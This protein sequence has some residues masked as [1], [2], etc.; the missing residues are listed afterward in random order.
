MAVQLYNTLTRR[1]EPLETLEPGRVKMYVCGVT[2]YDHCHLGHARAAI[3]FDVIRRYL[4][5]R[6]YQVTFVCNFTDVDDKIIARARRLKIPIGQLTEQFIAEYYNDMDALGVRRADVSPRATENID[7]MVKMIQGLM[8]KGLAYAGAGDVYYD[9]SR[10]PAYG[11]L[12]HRALEELEAG[13]RVE[14]GEGK[15]HPLDFALWKASKP[16]EPAWDSPWGPGRPGWHIEC[17]VMSSRYLG[18]RFDIHGGGE[19]LI[20]PHHE[21]EIAQSEGCFGHD[22][23]RYWIHNGFVRINHEKMSKSKGN[24]F[25]IK[26]VLQDIP[27]EVVRFFLLGSHYRHPVDYSDQ[28]VGEAWRGLDRLYNLLLRLGLAGPGEG[29]E[30]ERRMKEEAGIFRARFAEAMDDDFNSA[31]ALGHLFD[32]ARQAN[33]ILLDA[34]GALTRAAAAPAAEALREVGRVLGLFT[35]EPEEW[36]RRA[37][38]GASGEENN[39]QLAD[40]QI[41]ELIARRADAR[42]RKDFEEADRIRE[43]LAGAGV[44]LEDGPSGTIWKRRL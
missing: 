42:K 40:A 1:K 30:A 32:F 17:S 29:G 3:S 2:V 36:F 31:R 14:P 43:E 20:F 35:H 22:W 24:F 8:E 6:G 12:S 21:N 26:S 41:E 5:Y 4:E 23:V 33:S 13:S 27:A 10:F 7:G 16:E 38:P 37:R 39:G 18:E 15:R 28:V 11:K 19:D 34:G 9:I 44:L 25:T